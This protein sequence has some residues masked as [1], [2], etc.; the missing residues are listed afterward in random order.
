VN[1]HATTAPRLEVVNLSVT[2][3]MQNGHAIRPVRDVSFAL[4]PGSTLGVVGES[5]SGKSTLALAISKL[6]SPLVD[7]AFSGSVRLGGRDLLALSEKQLRAVRGAS[8][9]Y[10]FQSP[11]AA[12][13]PT[14]RVGTQIVQV[15]RAHRKAESASA[16]RE[17]ID[18]LERVGIESPSRAARRFPHELSGGM[19]QRVV[20]A[21]AVANRPA[22]L[23]ADEPTSSVDV[24]VQ[25]RILALLAQLRDD[26]GMAMIFI[27]HDLRVVSR[28]SDEVMVMY[29]G[30]MAEI[31]PTEAVLRSPRHWYTVGLLRSLPDPGQHYARD[32]RFLAIEGAPIS[33]EVNPAGCPFAER[34]DHAGPICHET[35]PEV[36]EAPE[37]NRYACWFPSAEP[38]N[39]TANAHGATLDD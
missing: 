31:G 25:D 39:R 32:H 10:V 16:Q 34:C 13:D 27:S 35:F 28:V 18:L 17:A 3:R 19:R 23:I 5:G 11:E 33:P 1:G 9:G 15:I 21:M 24:L 29:G 2:L 7:A 38:Q 36:V 30:R 14:Q 6:H 4:H 26:F 20:V 8:V 22:V 12:L 37:G